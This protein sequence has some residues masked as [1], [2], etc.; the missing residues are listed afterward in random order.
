VISLTS[1]SQSPNLTKVPVAGSWLGSEGNRSFDFKPHPW[2]ERLRSAFK[3]WDPTRNLRRLP[4][5]G[6]F[7]V[8]R[9]S[10]SFDYGGAGRTA[11]P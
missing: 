11:V 8:A 7:L 3:D 1:Y 9:F 5:W 2:N 6:E 4:S 10:Q